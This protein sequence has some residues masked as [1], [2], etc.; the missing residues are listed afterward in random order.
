MMS[1]GEMI[2]Y[3]FF[4]V[5]VLFIKYLSPKPSLVQIQFMTLIDI[6]QLPRAAGF[7]FF[8]SQITSAVVAQ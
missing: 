6:G 4:I 5:S 2:N 1:F 7:P 3:D 8:F